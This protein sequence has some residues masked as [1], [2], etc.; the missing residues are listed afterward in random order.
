MAKSSAYKAYRKLKASGTAHEWEQLISRR[1]FS[2]IPS[3][4]NKIAGRALS[5]LVKKNDKGTSFLERHN[6]VEAYDGIGLCL[7]ILMDVFFEILRA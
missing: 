4:F 3:I 1:E 7:R 2:K 5:A 6:L